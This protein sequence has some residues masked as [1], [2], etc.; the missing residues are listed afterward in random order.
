MATEGL[1]SHLEQVVRDANAKLEALGFRWALVGGLAVSA[2]SEPRFTRD[3]ILA[4]D[5]D[6]RPQ[7]VIDIQ[8]LVQEATEGD[9]KRAK[10]SLVLIAKRGYHRSRDL[11]A[12]LER[13]L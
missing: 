5:D 9:L 2:R 6:L 10:Q 12:E 4:R 1:A 7:D 3:K 13:V 8:A 11:V